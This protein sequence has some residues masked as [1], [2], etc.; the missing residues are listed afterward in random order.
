MLVA[1]HFDKGH[2]SSDFL[3]FAEEFIVPPK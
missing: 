2:S 3:V 1:R